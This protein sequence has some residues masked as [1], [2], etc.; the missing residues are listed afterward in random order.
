MLVR[1]VDVS[2]SQNQ[3]KSRAGR[4][5]LW[6]AMRLCLIRLASLEPCK[7]SIS[8]L[9]PVT[10]RVT[11]SRIVAFCGEVDCN[12][13]T[14]CLPAGRRPLQAPN[15]THHNIVALLLVRCAGISSRTELSSGRPWSRS[16]PRLLKCPSHKVG[17]DSCHRSTHISTSHRGGCVKMGKPQRPPMLGPCP[18]YAQ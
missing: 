14:C 7:L 18:M 4:R 12:E 3:Q 16:H 9:S 10:D 15:A 8:S 1:H 13:M 11:R 6:A 17:Y 2:I 5:Y